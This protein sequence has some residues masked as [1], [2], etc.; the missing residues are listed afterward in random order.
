M[1]S[2]SDYSFLE[3]H[4]NV[5]KILEIGT[6]RSTMALM[7]GGA[8]IHTIDRD[9]H[10]NM[11][12]ARQYHMESEVFWQAY[13]ING[14]DLFFIDGSIGIGD[15]EEIYDRANDKFKVIFHDYNEG[16]THK[17][18]DK[19]VHNYNIM[20]RYVHDKCHTEFETGGTHCA[21]LECEKI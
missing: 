20:I 6:G 14:F 12:D 7:T 18:F 4:N 16:G 2:D 17:N 15:I 5:D 8:E 9:Y 1:I 21:L 10:S 3:K 11:I 19:G 13:D